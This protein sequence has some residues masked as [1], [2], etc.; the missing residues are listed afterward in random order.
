MYRHI[1]VEGMRTRIL[2]TYVVS[3]IN[4]IMIVIVVVVVA[5]HLNLLVDWGIHV[6]VDW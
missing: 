5:V 3:I 6:V 2:M 4:N 1:V